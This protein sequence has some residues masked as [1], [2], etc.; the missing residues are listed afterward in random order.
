MLSSESAVPRGP[1][2]IRPVVASIVGPQQ[3]GRALKITGSRLEH[4]KEDGSAP[5]NRQSP[6][7]KGYFGLRRGPKAGIFKRGLLVPQRTFSPSIRDLPPDGQNLS[8]RLQ[9]DWE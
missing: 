8:A 3:C 6:R 2:I 5:E 7:G 1:A 9:G 4:R